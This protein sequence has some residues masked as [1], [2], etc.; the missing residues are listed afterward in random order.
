MNLNSIYPKNYIP[1]EIEDKIFKFIE[2]REIIAVRGPRQS[3]KTTLLLKLKKYLEEKHGSDQVVFINFE[4]ELEKH[5]FEKNPKDY[6]EFFLKNNQ[7][8]YFLLD[9]V[10]Y[11]KKGG[12]ILKLIYDTYPNLK[13]IVSGSSTLDIAKLGEYLVGRIVYFE[14]F[15]FSFA[16][17]LRAKD[18]RLFREYKNKKFDFEDPK[19]ID[20]VHLDKLNQQLNEYLTFGGYPRIVLEK[21]EQKKKI[22]LKNI[23]SAYIEKD[24][25]KLYGLKYKDQAISLLKYLSSTFTDL[26]NYNDISQI[27]SLHFKEVKQI[28]NIFEDTYLI[29]KISP[30]HRN[31]VTEL[32]KNPKYYFL[33]FGLRNTLSGKFTFTRQEQG[34]LLEN[35][36]LLAL[37]DKSLT[38]WRTTAKAEVDFILKDEII[39]IEVKS[40]PKITRALLSFIRHYQP[41]FSLVVNRK[42]SE[43]INKDGHK[44]Y[45]L[46]L[47]HL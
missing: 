14:L 35:Y 3:G 41:E 36:V 33:D 37:K 22:L 2:D 13:F 19:R 31:L 44:I 4:D 25:V 29:R 17:L 39:P 9:E 6:L 38:F 27:L 12:K 10:Q 23:F 42:Q 5:K 43:E 24:I 15:P 32:K 34:K 21:D 40:I 45:Y 47:A 30:F 26:I 20:S 7:R 28:L 46:P 8:T 18:K 11:L 16:E 1:R